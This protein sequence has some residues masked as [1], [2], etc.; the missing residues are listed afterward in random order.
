M[1]AFG[2]NL[3]LGNGLGEVYPKY[4]VHDG[5]LDNGPDAV[6]PIFPHYNLMCLILHFEGSVSM[7]F[8]MSW[9]MARIHPRNMLE[10]IPCHQ[11]GKPKHP[12]GEKG[13]LGHLGV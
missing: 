4:G 5:A 13:L 1:S 11:Y 6:V 7:S 2:M 12:M 10:N 9:T 8:R 3:H